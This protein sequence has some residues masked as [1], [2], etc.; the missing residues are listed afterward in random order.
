MPLNSC[1]RCL[2]S[3]AAVLTNRC[4]LT[5]CRQ[6]GRCFSGSRVTP[7]LASD[8]LIGHLDVTEDGTR[9]MAPGGFIFCASVASTRVGALDPALHSQSLVAGHG[10]A[11][12]RILARSPGGRATSL[13][14]WQAVLLATR[15]PPLYLHC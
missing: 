3:N 8:R 15:L 13:L 4:P 9:I 6:T 1:G 12:T 7:V 14:L 11:P 10:P 2:T 5:D